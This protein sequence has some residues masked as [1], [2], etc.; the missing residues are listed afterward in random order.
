MCE[1]M[2]QY[3]DI[4]YPKKKPSVW[5]RAW[6]AAIAL[7]GLSTAAN[8]QEDFID[9][10]IDL[11]EQTMFIDSTLGAAA[12]PVSTGRKGFRTPVGDFKPQRLEEMWYSK[13][14]DDAPM[15]YSI[16]FYEGYAIHGTQHVDRLGMPASHGCVRLS[17]DNAA[18]LYEIVEY[19]G[20]ENT[21]IRVQP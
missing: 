6:I 5:K 13:K 3:E 14:Y 16:F 12:W 17:E 8:A 19:V 18:V 11:S 7:V 2:M 1:P 21:Y 10:T 15:P 4:V 9:I 20:P